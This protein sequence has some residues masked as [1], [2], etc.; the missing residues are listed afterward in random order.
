MRDKI[1]IA[2]SVAIVVGLAGYFWSKHEECERQ[3][4]QMVRTILG[5]GW[6]CGT[7]VR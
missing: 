1:A 7:V 5:F 3:G 4:L 2:F 6:S